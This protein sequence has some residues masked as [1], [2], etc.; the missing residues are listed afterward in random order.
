MNG[1]AA[2]Y[3]L[4]PTSFKPILDSR[5]F[6]ALVPERNLHQTHKSNIKLIKP[7][8]VS[9]INGTPPTAHPLGLAP[10]HPVKLS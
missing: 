9:T 4:S 3:L 6:A 1:R 7:P 2:S 5:A 8:R 10:V